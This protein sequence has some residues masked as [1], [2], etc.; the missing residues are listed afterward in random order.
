[1]GM[2]DQRYDAMMRAVDLAR[3]GQFNNWWTIAAHLRIKRYQQ[4][5]LDWTENQRLWLDRLCI[6]TR[7]LREER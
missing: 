2:I 5:A 7:G 1:M 6:E 4:D 3:S